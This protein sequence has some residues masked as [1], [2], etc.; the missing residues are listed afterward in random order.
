MTE[1]DVTNIIIAVV[2]VVGTSLG[3]V[4]G[5]LITYYTTR[6]NERD[7]QIREKCEEIYDCCV[8]VTHWID[9]EIDCWWEHY[10]ATMIIIPNLS[11]N[12]PCPIDKLLMLVHL[13]APSLEE[14]ALKINTTVDK[15]HNLEYY[16]AE[17]EWSAFQ[18]GVDNFLTDERQK[19]R[20][21]QEEFVSSI[22]KFVNIH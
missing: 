11:K 16:Y 2:G 6:K 1:A 4:L 21:T 19:N 22:R 12:L 17:A 7:R 10:D 18:M 8:Q 3:A 13:Y 9:N 20:N 15:F 5:G 14:K